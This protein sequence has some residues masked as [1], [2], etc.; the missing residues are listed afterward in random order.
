[1]ITLTVYPAKKA[2]GQGGIVK[3]GVLTMRLN[4]SY[5]QV[6]T[7]VFTLVN[8]HGTSTQGVRNTFRDT[9]RE[10]KTL[11]LLNIKRRS[12]GGRNPGTRQG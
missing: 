3:E 4:A 7:R 1:M 6:T 11:L 5:V 8:H 9:D 2:G 12:T 10:K